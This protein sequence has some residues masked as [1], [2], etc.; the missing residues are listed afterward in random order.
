MGRGEGQI[1][2]ERLIY[3]RFLKERNRFLSN[4][5]GKIVIFLV[6]KFMVDCSPIS[7]QTNRSKKTAGSSQDS[8]EIIKAALVWV[9]PKVPF[10]HDPGP[11]SPGFKAFW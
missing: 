4:G 6:L 10:T 1:E 5:M 7:F 8:I 11:V 2:K 3:P 9:S